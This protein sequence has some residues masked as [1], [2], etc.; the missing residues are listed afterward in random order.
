MAAN[1]PAKAKECAEKSLAI[2]WNE[3]VQKFIEKLEKQ[4]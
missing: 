4:L 2:E 1:N 3:T